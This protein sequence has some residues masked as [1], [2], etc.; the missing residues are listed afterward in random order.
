MK[1]EQVFGNDIGV[2]IKADQATS[3]LHFIIGGENKSGIGPNGE[4]VLLALTKTERDAL[5]GMPIGALIY[6]TDDKTGIYRYDGTSWKKIPASDTLVTNSIPFVDANG[7][8]TNDNKFT[9]DG[10]NLTVGNDGL[11]GSN[12]INFNG[13]R[14]YIESAGGGFTMAVSGGSPADS[15][16]SISFKNVTR[17]WLNLYLPA[18]DA[19]TTP[20]E[21]K[22]SMNWSPG[23]NKSHNLGKSGTRWN[24][25][26]VGNINAEIQTAPTSASD[27]GE[28]GELRIT[29]DYIYV[30]VATD[31]WK[32]VALSTW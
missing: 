13:G 14:G 18:G 31:T 1:H 24:K 12:R 4:V 22:A 21:G 16:K 30:C 8:L 17:E 28:A 10:N 7:D 23:S 20:L 27:T 32:R 2:G 11:Y 29:N 3:R 19:G 5:T 26:Y 6:Q 15:S 9:Y 25:A